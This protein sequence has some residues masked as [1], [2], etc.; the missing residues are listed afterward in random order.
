[1]MPHMQECYML[2]SE[3]HI[4]ARGDRK[5]IM[6]IEK[7]I[8]LFLIKKHNRKKSKFYGVWRP[9]SAVP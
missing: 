6:Q 1:M 3:L 7:N 5:F 9:N 8:F 2:F 4:L